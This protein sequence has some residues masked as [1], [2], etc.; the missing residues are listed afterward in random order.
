[1]CLGDA[2]APWHRAVTPAPIKAGVL[3]MALTTGARPPVRRAM[4]SV[5]TDA[6]MEMMS[7][8]GPSPAEP[9]DFKAPCT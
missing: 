7:F 4:T 1:M 9:M 2:L 3:G 5:V 8:P 6:A